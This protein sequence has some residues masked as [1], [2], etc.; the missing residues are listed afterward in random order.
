MI[1]LK[2]DNSDDSIAHSLVSSNFS[3]I[4]AE[5]Y[6][7]L[8]KKEEDMQVPE[9]TLPLNH[10]RLDRIRAF[11]SYNYKPFDFDV[12][13]R[14]FKDA[15]KEIV[16]EAVRWVKTNHKLGGEVMKKVSSQSTMAR[17]IIVANRW[18][19]QKGYD[20]REFWTQTAVREVLSPNKFSYMKLSAKGALLQLCKHL[21]EEDIT[22]NLCSSKR[23]FDSL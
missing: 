7:E 21:H 19:D 11:T 5:R 15:P 22:S 23:S 20:L 18:L 16:D 8:I 12:F 6:R 4:A 14:S 13:R 3:H 17:L 2:S 1:R 9:Q 10:A